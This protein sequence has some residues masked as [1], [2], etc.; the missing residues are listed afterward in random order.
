MKA[1]GRPI[2]VTA[3]QTRAAVLAA[4]AAE[5]SERGYARSSIRRIAERAG[6]TSAAIYYHFPTKLACLEAVQ[7][8]ALELMRS[9]WD[10]IMEGEG[11]IADRVAQLLRAAAQINTVNPHMAKI[12][13]RIVMED[14]GGHPEMSS[15]AE[16]ANA[17]TDAIYEKLVADAFARGEIAQGASA[18]AVL[19]MIR[20]LML[21]LSNVA[22]FQYP[23]D[24]HAAAL[25]ALAELLGGQLFTPVDREPVT[26]DY[27]K[28]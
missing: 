6:L 7:N 12:S 27:S 13:A 1:I 15:V 5:F 25:D 8:D 21:G 9:Y 18:Q 4:A 16:L 2:G 10:P 14:A 23:V 11:H 20:G 19:D 17:Y 28:R 24:R 3:D 22:A 26:A